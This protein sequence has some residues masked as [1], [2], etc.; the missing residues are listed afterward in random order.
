MKLLRQGGG[1]VLDSL[2]E[3]I[4]YALEQMC[5]VCTFGNIVEPMSYD[6]QL[7]SRATVSPSRCGIFLLLVIACEIENNL[8]K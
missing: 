5:F 8:G 7:W 4:S 1:A 2:Y 6:G 3:N